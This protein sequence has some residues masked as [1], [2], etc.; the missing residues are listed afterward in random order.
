MEPTELELM[1]YEALAIVKDE[2]I[3]NPFEKTEHV[4]IIRLS[5]LRCDEILKAFD[6]FKKAHN[7]ELRRGEYVRPE[8]K[9]NSKKKISA[10][11]TNHNN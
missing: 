10:P 2:I 9:L 6:E 4:T 8:I 5:N 7:L 1:L 3:L 11:G